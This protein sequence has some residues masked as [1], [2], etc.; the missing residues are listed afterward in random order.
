MNAHYHQQGKEPILCEVV[1]THENG[2][3]DL[4][5][6][7]G[8]VFVTECEVVDA[9][10]DGYA[11]LIEEKN[12]G[13]SLKG[14][15]AKV[16]NATKADEAAKAALA[17]KPEDEVLIS[18]AKDAAEALEAAKAALAAAEAPAP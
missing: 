16:T 15:R 17:A 6:I 1:T 11:T 18:A 13:P 4:R 12:Q 9:P 2:T 7:G 3:V 14:L 10:Q 5:R 8:S